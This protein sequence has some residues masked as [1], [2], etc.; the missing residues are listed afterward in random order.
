MKNFLMYVALPVAIVVF[1]AN[2]PDVWRYIKLRN[3]S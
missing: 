2:L 3:M 1:A